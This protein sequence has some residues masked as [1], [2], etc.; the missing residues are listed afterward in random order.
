MHKSTYY[1]LTDITLTIL[2]QIEE[3]FKSNKDEAL[4]IISNLI[5]LKRGQQGYVPI[6]YASYRGNLI[7]IRKFIDYGANYET[8]NNEGLNVLHL[9]AQGNQP[10]SIVYFVEEKGMILN[11]KDKV[12]STPLHWACY[13]GAENSIDFILSYKIDINSQDNEGLTALHLAVL[14][15]K[16]IYLI[17]IRLG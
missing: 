7:L 2:S 14:S 12:G 11:V 3:R 8:L 5:N 1:D 6:H 4:N 9:A 16:L 17:E 15:G 10:L 13:I